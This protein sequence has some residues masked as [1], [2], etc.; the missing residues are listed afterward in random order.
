LWDM[1]QLANA[2]SGDSVQLMKS[3]ASASCCIYFSNLR[4]NSS[5]LDFEISIC[6]CPCD[7]R[8]F[9]VGVE[10]ACVIYML[11]AGWNLDQSK[12]KGWVIADWEY[13]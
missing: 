10:Q 6:V 7:A 8:W 4:Q 13:Q 3:V 1:S 12:R 2:T 5:T 9:T 11:K